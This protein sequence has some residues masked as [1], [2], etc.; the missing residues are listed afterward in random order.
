MPTLVIYE[1]NVDP[2]SSS[3]VTVLNEYIVDV[4]DDDPFLQDPDAGGGLQLDVSGVPG[5]LGTSS[6]FQV[7]ETYSGNLAG[8]PVSF[9]LLQYSNP[10]YI[11]AT[12]GTFDVGDTITGTNNSI[13]TAP[14]S[15][16]STLPDYVCFCA[17]T[18][19]DTPGGPR[20]VG[21]LQVGDLV[22]VDGGRAKPIKWIGRNRLDADDLARNPHLR[23]IR[24][25]PDALAPGVPSRA[26]SVSPQHRIAVSAGASAVLLGADDVLVPAL[27][28]RAIDG[29]EVIADTDAVEY[30]HILLDDHDLVSA[31]GLWSETLFLGDTMMTA[32]GE[33]SHREIVRLFPQSRDR[34][35]GL[36]ETC[37][38]VV[39]PFEASTAVPDFGA[40]VAD[41]ECEAARAI[42]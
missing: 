27:C 12:Q 40:Y 11:I 39:R 17:D 4:I 2:L 25:A 26:V 19:I 5:F 7:F 15:T 23:P 41:R 16:Y 38:P 21:D 28:L 37:L 32:I 20:R 42:A 31:S 13:V 8:S 22:R 10:Q 6:N 33:Q 35:Q 14:P 24:F 3:N 18:L 30:V 36:M 29:V 1:I 9:T 34:G